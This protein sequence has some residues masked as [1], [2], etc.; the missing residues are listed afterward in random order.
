MF[1]VIFTC[2]MFS[3]STAHATPFSSIDPSTFG[4][5]IDGDGYFSHNGSVAISVEAA[6]VFN[7]NTL[8]K[9]EFGFFFEGASDTLISIFDITEP[10]LAASL[11]DFTDGAVVDL[12]D[13]N[14][15]SLFTPSASDYGFYLSIFDI[16]ND[17]SGILSTTIFSDATLNGGADLF[18][19]FDL[20]TSDVPAGTLTGMFFDNTPGENWNLLYAAPLITISEPV[21]VSEPYSLALLGLGLTLLASF[22]RR[23]RR[24]A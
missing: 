2:V 12:D 19:A 20:L 14:I 21:A 17:P 8:Q 18:G 16:S 11:I 15:E 6:D 4:S 3:V 10:L 1:K 23:Q 24:L 7:T 9:F 22:K 13:G 5:D